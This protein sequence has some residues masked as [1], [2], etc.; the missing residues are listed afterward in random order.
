MTKT[1]AKAIAKQMV[2]TALAGRMQNVRSEEEISSKLEQESIED[3][4]ENMRLV[5]S[6]VEKIID[7]LE[8]LVCNIKP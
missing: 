1:E 2:S 4:E 5:Q 7:R 3:S 6:Y 8:A